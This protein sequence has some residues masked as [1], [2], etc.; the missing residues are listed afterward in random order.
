MVQLDTRSSNLCLDNGHFFKKNQL[1]VLSIYIVV[2]AQ[3]QKAAP[4]GPDNSHKLLY[5]LR[6]PQLDT[7]VMRWNNRP[8]I[9]Y[10][11]F[12]KYSFKQIIE[13]FLVFMKKFVFSTALW[14]LFALMMSWVRVWVDLDL[15]TT[16]F[17][18]KVLLDTWKWS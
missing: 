1:S 9:T 12:E 7:E 16:H 4:L 15:F 2:L 6:I 17:S 8:V 3:P 13:I 14:L 5:V 10:F 18:D 11:E